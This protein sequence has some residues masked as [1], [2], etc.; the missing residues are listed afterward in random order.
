MV[1]KHI[2]IIGLVLGICCFI[3]GKAAIPTWQVNA[4]SYQFSMTVTALLNMD[5]YIS[6]DSNDMVGAF[7]NGECRG[8]M[9]PGKYKTH[10]GYRLVFLQIYSNTIVGEQ[11]TFK[12]Y[13]ASSDAPFTPVNFLVFKND[14]SAGTPSDPYVITTDHKPIDIQLSSNTI[15][16]QM[17]VGTL[18]GLL[19]TTD[20]DGNDQFVYSLVSGT[21]DD[22]NQNFF[23]K[24]NGLYTSVVFSTN[25]KSTYSIRIQT[26]DQ[27]GG[28]F[29]KAFSLGLNANEN[30]LE[31]S[32]YISPNGDGRN[33]TWEITNLSYFQNCQVTIYST[34]G[35]VVFESSNYKNDWNGTHN[36]SI[37]PDGVYYYVVKKN[38][39]KF[40]GSITLIN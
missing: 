1:Y 19:S 10:E 29:S 26:D 38:S 3:H 34:A 39:Q 33:D 27:K 35:L 20:A 11:V 16:E 18:I 36:G 28:V 23:I 6:S 24:D 9:H 37:L 21:G 5:G 32:N 15:I 25:G 7:I 30:V 4:S 14:T 13:K 22:D 8:V 17:K 31:A 40:S 2:Q 12:M